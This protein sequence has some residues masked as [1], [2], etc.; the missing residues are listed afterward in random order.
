MPAEKKRI[1]TSYARLSEDLERLFRQTY[2]KGYDHEV[3]PITK[4]NGET[5]Y[6]VRLETEDTSY[7]VK[8]EVKIGTAGDDDEDNEG[9]YDTDA[10]T[11]EMPDDQFSDDEDSDKQGGYDSFDN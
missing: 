9:G 7:L 4:P 11:D 5:I 1:I 10:D 3:M 2:P 8:V 6:V